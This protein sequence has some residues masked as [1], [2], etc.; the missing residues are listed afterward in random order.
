MLQDKR[1]QKIDNARTN[2]PTA[3][4][5]MLPH[6]Y[7]K[8]LNRIEAAQHCTDQGFKTSPATLATKASR[9]GGPA[10][11]YWGSK[12]VYDPDD[13]DEWIASKVTCKVFSTAERAKAN[14]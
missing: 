8:R 4:K 11:S 5:N 13:L 6:K 2:D 12:P 14:A 7:K 3:S 9:G 10:F 1:T